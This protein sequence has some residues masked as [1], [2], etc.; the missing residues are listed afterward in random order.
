MAGILNRISTFTTVENPKVWI[1][2][3]LLDSSSLETETWPV[4]LRTPLQSSLS[5][6]FSG[7]PTSAVWTVY[8]GKGFPGLT[9]TSVS[10]CLPLTASD[11]PLEHVPSGSSSSTS[12]K[13]LRIRKQWGGSPDEVFQQSDVWLFLFS[14]SKTRNP[15]S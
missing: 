11:S 10:L 4:V 5:G 2:S 15:D 12:K 6:E 13:V 7:T 14:C 8:T 9:L 3:H 1:R